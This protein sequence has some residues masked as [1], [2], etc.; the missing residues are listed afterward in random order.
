VRNAFDINETASAPA[1]DGFMSSRAR[2]RQEAKDA[3]QDEKLSARDQREED[4]R[5]IRNEKR[6]L[7]DRRYILEN[8][9]VAPVDGEQ[10][11][12]DLWA[13]Q[14]KHGKEGPAEFWWKVVPKLEQAQLTRGGALCPSHLKPPGA[15]SLTETHKRVAAALERA[16][17]NVR[18]LEASQVLQGWAMED[19][20]L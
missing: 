20:T 13:L 7:R 8:H 10:F 12:T 3:A 9:T 11:W 19:G 18:T 15:P 5:R 2:E 1:D 16:S 6:D 14:R 17:H 4:R